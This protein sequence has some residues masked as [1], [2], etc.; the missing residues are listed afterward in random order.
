MGR[1]IN[2]DVDYLVHLHVFCMDPKSGDRNL[3]LPKKAFVN[4]FSLKSKDL[5]KFGLTNEEK[6]KI[7]STAANLAATP[8]EILTGGDADIQ[9][10]APS[11]ITI[12]KAA[13]D[14]VVAAVLNKKNQ[15]KQSTASKKQLTA[16]AEKK[17][18]RGGRKKGATKWVIDEIYLL[19]DCAE[20]ILPIGGMEWDLVNTKFHDGARN[21]NKSWTR[22]SEAMK[23][24]FEKL[25]FLKP[26]TG[27]TEMPEHV[28]RAKEIKELLDRK[29]A[30]GSGGASDDAMNLP[31]DE[32][33]WRPVTQ[34]CVQQA[35]AKAMEQFNEKAFTFMDRMCDIMSNKRQK[36]GADVD[37]ADQN[38]ESRIAELEKSLSI[39]SSNV[40]L[41]LQK[42]G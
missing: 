1:T 18:G 12:A 42:L 29:E 17:D 4:L 40:L 3:L 20:D 22:T 33:G 7:R 39:M 2:G 5:E 23:A 19:L 31:V 27:G 28:R 13:A 16:S 15:K 38:V 10:I 8:V 36:L 26:P 37:A 41:I 25:C 30:M 21:Q 14:E 6:E 24:Y 11:N 34:R 32:N 9:S 35:T